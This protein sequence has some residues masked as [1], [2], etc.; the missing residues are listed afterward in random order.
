MNKRYSGSRWKI[1]EIDEG[2]YAFKCMGEIEGNRWL[3]GDI[4]KGTVSLVPEV[5]DQ[6]A[7]TRWKIYN[8]EEK[9]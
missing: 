7:G 4:H 8:I 5:N 2:I 3:D 9:R 6:Y 1:F